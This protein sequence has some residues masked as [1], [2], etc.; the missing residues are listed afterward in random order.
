MV[1]V[2][3]LGS[4]SQDPDNLRHHTERNVN[5]IAKSIATVGPARPIVTDE[6]DVI[7]AGNATQQ[8][9]LQEGI[10]SAQVIETD[11]ETIIAVR[12]S[13][14]TAQEKAYLALSDN[15]AAGLATWKGDAIKALMET[16]TGVKAAVEA[17]WYPQELETLLALPEVPAV[18]QG[19]EEYIPNRMEKAAPSPMIRWSG[20]RLLCTEDDAA[21][22]KAALLAHQRQHG[23]FAGLMPAALQKTRQLLDGL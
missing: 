20:Y 19:H 13:G 17:N 16:D 21:R 2:V 4:L 5:V 15:R 1:T 23:S 10:T 8:A 14:L 18:N 9:A 3:P 22:L 11:G 6:N 12:V 7:L